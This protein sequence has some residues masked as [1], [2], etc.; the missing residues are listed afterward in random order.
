MKEYKNKTEIP[1]FYKIIFHKNGKYPI[2][3]YSRNLKIK[4][5]DREK[6]SQTPINKIRNELIFPI[7]DDSSLKIKNMY[8][9]FQKAKSAKKNNVNLSYNYLSPKNILFNKKF[10]KI[11]RPLSQYSTIIEMSK[12]NSDLFYK[13]IKKER[14]FSQF[15]KYS[16]LNFDNIYSGNDSKICTNKDIFNKI[17]PKSGLR[18]RI[19]RN[20]SALLLRN[21]KSN[22]FNNSSIKDLLK[23]ENDMK[24]KKKELKGRLLTALSKHLVI[25]KD[26]YNKFNYLFKNEDSYEDK[27]LK[28]EENDKKNNKMKMFNSNNHPSSLFSELKPSFRYEDYYHSPLEFVIKYFTK[29]EIKLLKSSPEYF[30]I[31]RLPFKNSDF[32]YYPTLLSKLEHEKNGEDSDKSKKIEK[33]VNEESNKIDIKNELNRIRKIFKE[34]KKSKSKRKLII[35]KDFISH[36]EREIEADEGTVN[37]FERKYIKYLSNKEKR[38]E[39]KITNIKFKKSRFEFLKNKR[40]QKIEEDKN[41]QR[42]TGPVINAIKKNYLRSN[43][44]CS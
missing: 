21:K 19:I 6:Q 11:S 26:T 1:N 44:M 40:T 32:E 39:K 25:N 10:S 41:I 22:L 30:G 31:N 42:I 29:E 13:N 18:N 36:Y 38:M 4:I 37:Y 43:S 27:I 20:S 8:A 9:K 16:T 12:N 17:K 2:G 28:D 35:G 14:P 24:K 3:Y 5:K 23:H 7:S 34:K 15:N 33:F